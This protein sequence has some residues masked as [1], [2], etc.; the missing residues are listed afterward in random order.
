M[1]EAHP[2]RYDQAWL[3]R[4]ILNL[5]GWFQVS[6]W[7]ALVAL[8]LF[9]LLL[10]AF[11]I[12]T[13]LPESIL[14]VG[15]IPIVLLALY[16]ERR[17]A[18]L[19]A[20]LLLT[21]AGLC[22]AWFV[23]A[24]FAES[25]KTIALSFFSVIALCEVVF[26]LSMT[27]RQAQQAERESAALLE[28]TLNAIPDLIG[29]QGPNHEII[30][31]NEAGYKFLNKTPQEVI[32]TKCYQLIG[33]D[34]PCS[35]CATQ[36]VYETKSPAQVER[37]E[38]SMGLWLDVRAYPILDDQGHIV[39]VIEHLRD[40]TD[41]KRAEQALRQ[42]EQF[43]QDVFDAIQDGISVLDRDLTILQVNRW[44]ERLYQEHMPLIGKKCFAVYQRRD[45]PCPWCPSLA[46][47]GSGQAQ[48]E[49]VPYPD[50]DAPSG[51]IEL[52]AFPLK[53]A[54]GQVSGVIEYVKD[55]T[56]RIKAEEERAK[57]QE[58]LMQAQKMEAIGRL[59]GG[60]AHDFNNMLTAIQGYTDILLQAFAEE[61]A[62]DYPS[63]ADVRADLGEVMAAAN[64]AQSL[65]AQL[66]AFSRKQIL[67]PQ[68]I[69][70]AEVLSSVESMLRRLI[71]EDIE[72]SR[73]VMSDQDYIQAD[74]GQIEQIVLNLA[75]NARD[76]MPNG[77]CLTFEVADVVL[78]EDFA[79]TH[80]A[81]KPGEYVLLAVSDTGVGMTDEVKAHLFEPFFTT[82]DVGKGTGLGLATVYA[83]VNQ[84]GGS[85][86]VYSEVGVGTTLRV[87][88]PRVVRP[89]T[90]GT[91]AMPDAHMLTGS[92]TILLAED[93]QLVRDLIARILTRS[94]YT[95]LTAER[96]IEALALG[97]E[98]GNP[99]DLLIADVVMPQIGGK[100]LSARLATSH[101][102][103]KV[104]FI[105]G[106]TS[107]AI[108]RHGVLDEGVNFIQKPFAPHSLAIK[109]REILDQRKQVDK[110]VEELKGS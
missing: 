35:V 57:L 65:T 55:I 105:S 79:Q 41:R 58:R 101:P 48:T 102:E 71:G 38:P 108:V 53:G 18:Y 5:A 13:G 3:A 10:S 22:T 19:T 29:I 70:V 78:D 23:S 80:P 92:E 93:E 87:Y 85:I 54:D 82:K 103:T 27:R 59:A 46:T 104:L 76:A 32:G 4:A 90:P 100:E 31:Y 88:L 8:A 106:Y 37:Y 81:L 109:V 84:L 12:F 75:V 67:R 95:V 45:S 110:Q 40:I 107:N 72:L 39:R 33:R 9:V 63:S 11:L 43:L 83:I 16:H 17:A 77:G 52:S 26:S 20:S 28:A 14:Y 25:L 64:R 98:Y 74:P 99:I 61:R 1:S 89:D 36:E 60:I 56:Q 50:V 51:W 86:G 69:G 62:D 15:L 42:S 2:K 6:T 96:P 94:G 7:Q 30:R 97:Q 47:L 24:N 44:M 21:L 73:H 49:I 66:L 68:V 91:R 34:T